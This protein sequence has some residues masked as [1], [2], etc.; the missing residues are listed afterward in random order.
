MSPE[1]KP[2]L[3]S[4]R[5]MIAI[6]V[7]ASSSAAILI[8]FAQQEASSLAVAAWRLGVG[9]LIMAPFAFANHR[10]TLRRMT[11]KE[12][13]L[14]LLSGLFLALHFAAWVTSLE[15]TTVASSVV[16]VT[17]S[18]LIV[19]LISTFVLKEPVG[20][21]AWL[22]MAIALAG[23]AMVAFGDQWAGGAAADTVRYAQ[24]MLGNLL[25][26]AGAVFVAGYLLLGRKLRASV[27]LPPYALT[28]FGTA[29]MVLAAAALF[30]GQKMAGFSPD[31]YLWFVLLGLVPQTIGHAG[32]NWALKYVP[33][34]FVS[35][36]LLGEPVGSSIFAALLLR[37]P[38][39]LY[40]VG[41]G[42]LILIGIY[43]ASRLGRK[44]P[45]AKTS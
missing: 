32:F 8:R 45:P 18:P 26:L 41:G 34:S 42:V 11:R 24:R 6:S 37:E 19:A 9:T 17:L 21:Y 20:K 27:P 36:A 10:D 1:E 38:P 44:S 7:L 31:I 3:I 14:A 43:L 33:A 4:P 29:A 5:L 28:V 39:T 25:A 2:G 30:S 40:E 15:Y 12:W 23:S 16:L 13:L 35:I 22:G